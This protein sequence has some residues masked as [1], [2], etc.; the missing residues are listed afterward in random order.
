M[1]FHTVFSVVPAR[2]GVVITFQNS[3]GLHLQHPL[4][5]ETTL[6]C[7]FVLSI[8]LLISGCFCGCDLIHPEDC[9]SLNS[10]SPFFSSTIISDY[11]CR[12]DYFFH[13]ASQL[14]QCLIFSNVACTVTALMAFKSQL[15]N[16]TSNIIFDWDK[17][18]DCDE[19][20][21]GVTF[22]HNYRVTEL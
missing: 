21:R 16:K 8:Y 2:Y 22:D 12:R 14:P 9:A 13:P 5:M 20:W 7:I 1:I 18:L 11:C 15:V 4:P 6:R 3:E 17:Q 19:G 10:V